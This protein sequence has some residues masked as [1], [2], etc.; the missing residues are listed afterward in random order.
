M[1]DNLSKILVVDN[2]QREIE[3]IS[4]AFKELNIPV[5]T[6]LYSQARPPEKPYSGIR[7]AFFDIKLQDGN[8]VE[9]QTITSF[10][11]ALKKCIATENGPFI[12][13]FWSSH[14][15]K[16]EAIKNH[17]SSRIKEEIP[18]PILVDY[19]D[20]TI[21]GSA[22]ALQGEIKRILSKDIIKILFDYENKISQAAGKTLKTLFNVVSNEKDTWGNSSHFEQNID[23]VFSN[24]ANETMGYINAKQNPLTAIRNGLNP[25]L[26]NE[27]NNINLSDEWKDKMKNLLESENKNKFIK[28]DQ[29][30][31]SKLNSI[32]HFNFRIDTL[33][34]KTRGI[35]VEIEITDNEMT[36]FFGK[37]INQIRH[38]IL[39]FN[40][41]KITK[42]EKQTIVGKARFV[43][44]EISASCDYAQDNHRNYSYILGVLIPKFD[45]SL[46]TKQSDSIIQIPE[47]QYQKEDYL[48]FFN[49]R[50]VLTT[51]EV[52]PSFLRSILFQIK[53]EL[54][55]K[56]TMQHSNYI[57]RL[58]IIQF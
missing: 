17:I 36:S 4:K 8:H 42:S 49:S 48:L 37:K 39:P 23:L 24:I 55:N 25:I 29:Q 7:I 16:I 1:L 40:S 20:K 30:H 51:T 53:I 54:M 35:V 18:T 19:I 9:I 15:D 26:T 41:E 50:Y 27:L 22:L 3:K 47:F 10:I 52:E 46:L 32:Y 12:L 43:L 6:L 14:A 2:E 13:I 56:I 34:K 57:S 58:G 33:T 44:L 21:A 5:Y 31:I 28:I 45:I 11:N 38:S